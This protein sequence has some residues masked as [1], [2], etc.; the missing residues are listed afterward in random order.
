MPLKVLHLIDSGGLYGAENV[1]INLSIGLQRV[2]QRSLIGCF[3]Y[4]GQDRPQLAIKAESLGLETVDFELGNKFDV[5]CIRQI[6]SFCKDVGVS[7][8]HSHGYKPSFLCLLLKAFYKI[9]YIITLHLWYIKNFK[10]NTY[11]MIETYCMRF[12]EHVVGVSQEIITDLEKRGIHANRL[13][14]IPN[15]IDMTPYSDYSG[16]DEAVLRKE[17]GLREDSFIIG[18]LGRLAHQKDYKTLIAAAAELL[19]KTN[20]VE[21]IIAGEGPLKHE[22]LNMIVDYNLQDNFHLLGFRTDTLSLLRVMDVFVLPSLDE[23]LPMAM[24]EAM[25]AKKPVVVTAVGGIPNVII[26]GINGIIMEK[27]NI[28]E[29]CDTLL[30]MKNNSEKDKELGESA[31]ATISNQYSCDKMSSEYLRIYNQIYA[32]G[33]YVDA[34]FK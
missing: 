9:P 20:N 33:N 23:G 30:F 7:L 19:K 1:I 18:S 26:D 28:R 8:I 31:F 4:K 12:A 14:F 32:M 34:N 3:R 24:L 15:G 2:G 22:L 5:T 11:A 21:F 10:L 25:A 13:T 27:G 29:L 16:F 6:A 17:L